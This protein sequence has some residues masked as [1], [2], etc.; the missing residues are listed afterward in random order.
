M[1]R[2]RGSV[3]VLDHGVDRGVAVGR[4]HDPVAAGRGQAVDAPGKR[5]GRS[6]EAGS[7]FLRQR[8]VARR[9]RQLGLDLAASNAPL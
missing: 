2:R 9:P 3:D 6:V 5:E 1:D 8:F 4:E 7:D